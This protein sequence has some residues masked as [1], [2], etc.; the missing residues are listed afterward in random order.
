[1]FSTAVATSTRGNS[2]ALAAT[3]PNASSRPIAGL[4]R[5]VRA[6]VNVTFVE[7]MSPPISPVAR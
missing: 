1:M 6:N 4:S 7:E 3:T 5:L 2:I